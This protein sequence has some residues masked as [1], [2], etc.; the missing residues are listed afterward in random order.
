M[1]RTCYVVALSV[2]V[3][4]IKESEIS[5]PGTLLREI[6]LILWKSTVEPIC[7]KIALLANPQNTP[8][9]PVLP[10]HPGKQRHVVEMGSM[11]VWKVLLPTSLSKCTIHPFALIP[12]RALPSMILAHFY[13]CNI[14]NPVHIGTSRHQEDRASLSCVHAE[15][16]KGKLRQKRSSATSA[17]NSS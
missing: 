3:V 13:L 6:A 1:A 2:I 16:Q 9:L 14:C 15:A 5:G 10:S 12:S 8:V 11:S 4:Y 7:R 17:R